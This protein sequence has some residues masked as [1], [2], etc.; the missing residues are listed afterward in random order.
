M[1]F[2]GALLKVAKGEPVFQP[3]AEGDDFKAER[4]QAALP[5]HQLDHLQPPASPQH[6]TGPKVLP[7]VYIEQVHTHPNGQNLECEFKIRNHSHVP[8]R[9][10]RL[11]FLGQ[12]YNLNKT[13][14]QPDREWEYLVHTHRPVSSNYHECKLYFETEDGDDFV[15]AHTVEY[16]QLPDHTY[17]VT[18]VRFMSPVRDI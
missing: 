9:L 10:E 13:T 17:N 16:Q 6:P 1:G 18:H 14:L 12:N 2:F 15:S 3:P 5:S 7:N 11:E 8:V 4:G